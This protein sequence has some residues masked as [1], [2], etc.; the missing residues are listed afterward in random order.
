MR[1]RMVKVQGFVRRVVW[2]HSGC[3]VQGDMCV[4]VCVRVSSY[5]CVNVL[6]VCR[7]TAKHGIL[8][9]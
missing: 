2:H 4:S 3:D 1:V 8:V 5:V 7:K 9:P 6:G